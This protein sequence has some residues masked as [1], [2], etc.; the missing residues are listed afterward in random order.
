MH[1]P[2][3]YFSSSLF[4]LFLVVLLAMVNVSV[5]AAEPIAKETLVV[6]D[7]VSSSGLLVTDTPVNDLSKAATSQGVSTGQYMNLVLGL[8]A[9][10]GFI[11]LVAWILRRVNGAPSSSVGAM[12][13]VGGLSLGNR[14]RVVLLQVGE[15]QIL[16]G[17]SP[18][19][20]NLIHAF[21]EPP[22]QTES[23]SQGS[24]FY[25]KLQASLNRGSKS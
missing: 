20:I 25:Q 12:K 9:I 5:Q 10:I 6:S 3:N 7:T 17:A 1:K 11:F 16:L 18:G 21:E 14:D 4:R 24:D 2:V 13:I 23:A 22:I 8:V 15:Q 19:N